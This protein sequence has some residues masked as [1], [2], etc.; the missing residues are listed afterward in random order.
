MFKFN[1]T[2]PAS[3]FGRVTGIHEQFVMQ[4]EERELQARI[5]RANARPTSW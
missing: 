5:D 4:A 3:Y 1:N 2:K